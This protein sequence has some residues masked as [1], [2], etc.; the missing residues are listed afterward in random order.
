MTATLERAPGAPQSIEQRV[1]QSY[2][3]CCM[4][5]SFFSDFYT[6]FIGTSPQIR[7]KFVNTDFKKQNALLR[8]GIAFLI[9]YNA[10]SATATSAINRLGQSH[11]KG[12]LNIDPS[13]YELWIG[14]LMRTVKKHDRQYTPLLDAEW[15]K[16]L[17]KGI[18]SMKSAYNS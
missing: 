4:S 5:P 13:M 7:A 9:M 16:V 2:G 10:G 12:A 11:A 17:N 8:Q 15:R 6:D 18:A 1:Q 14:A 3:R